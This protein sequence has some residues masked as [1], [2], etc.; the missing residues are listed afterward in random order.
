GIHGHHDNYCSVP[1]GRDGLCVRR[2]YCREA[3]NQFLKPCGSENIVCCPLPTHR[4][5]RPSQP[6]ATSAPRT[7][8]AT[9][10]APERKPNDYD[11][12]PT[13]QADYNRPSAHR[14]GDQSDYQYPDPRT[15]SSGGS[16]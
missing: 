14:P 10:K 15:P 12:R 5:A 4:S 6:F 3:A 9:T 11:I 13:K 16:G 2:R 7:T 1:D 8:E